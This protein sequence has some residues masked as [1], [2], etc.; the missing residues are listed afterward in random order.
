MGQKLEN[1]QFSSAQWWTALLP[2]HSGV[3]NQSE[4]DS[5]CSRASA[6]KCRG[7]ALQLL[8]DPSAGGGCKR[9]GSDHCE[10]ATVCPCLSWLQASLG[11]TMAVPW[12]ISFRWPSTR[13]CM[14]QRTHWVR[15]LP[16]LRKSDWTQAQRRRHPMLSSM[17]PRVF[18]TTLCSSRWRAKQ[19]QCSRRRS[20]E[21]SLVAP[22]CQGSRQAWKA[23]RSTQRPDRQKN[24]F[25][26]SMKVSDENG[27]LVRSLSLTSN[28]TMVT[29]RIQIVRVVREIG[30]QPLHR[31]GVPMDE[32]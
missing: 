12:K 30:S 6:V 18:S 2:E 31:E 8:D 10:V 21:T 4:C 25:V 17:L 16:W 28:N 11:G 26:T 24:S 5:S 13:A 32:E 1:S 29:E 14:K 20:R 22:G 27:S 7:Q 19:A 23:A 3:K 15:R 9:R